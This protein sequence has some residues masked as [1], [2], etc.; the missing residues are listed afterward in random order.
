MLVVANGKRCL[1]RRPEE[2]GFVP[3]KRALT[4]P[5]RGGRV[6]SAVEEEKKES[7]FT[8]AFLLNNDDDDGAPKRLCYRGNQTQKSKAPPI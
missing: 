5:L 8:R 1:G 3:Q 2:G 7:L 6:R 4:P